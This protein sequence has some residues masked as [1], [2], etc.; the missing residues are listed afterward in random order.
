MP[1]GFPFERLA[2]VLPDV[3]VSQYLLF[4]PTRELLANYNYP[5]AFCCLGIQ[6]MLMEFEANNKKSNILKGLG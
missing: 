1:P 3:P 5:W 4:L 6:L 2:D